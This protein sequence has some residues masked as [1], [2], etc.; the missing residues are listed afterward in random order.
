MVK[1]V[2]TT[3]IVDF[4]DNENDWVSVK[5][6]QSEAYGAF[7]QP[8]K[9][10]LSY[11]ILIQSSIATN[12]LTSIDIMYTDMYHQSTEFWEVL[13]IQVFLFE[14]EPPIFITTPEGIIVDQC[15]IK[16]VTLPEIEDPDGTL[17]SSLLDVISLSSDTPSSIYLNNSQIVFNLTDTKISYA[18]LNSITVILTDKT[19]AFTK[20]VINVTVGTYS[21]PDFSKVQNITLSSQEQNQVQ[22]K[23][24]IISSYLPSV[25]N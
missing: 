20:N 15:N 17:P 8:I 12:N 11:S 2:L 3:F 13:R 18:N 24:D 5:I 21:T 25:V 1:N 23:V 10:N 14:S 22:I 16:E 9:G 7:A 4:I 6:T 19:G